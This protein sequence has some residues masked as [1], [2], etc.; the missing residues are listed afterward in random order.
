MCSKCTE[1]IRQE[2]SRES[3][4]K[5]ERFFFERAVLF[6]RSSLLREA[7]PNQPEGW[8]HNCLITELTKEETDEYQV[9]AQCRGDQMYLNLM[10]YMISLQ[11]M[12]LITG[13]L[14]EKTLGEMGRFIDEHFGLPP[15]F[16]DKPLVLF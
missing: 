6:N 13:L 9:Y 4:Q 7:D 5:I 1:K 14:S 3:M 11:G 8:L 10:P 12:E 16:K 2:I 15:E